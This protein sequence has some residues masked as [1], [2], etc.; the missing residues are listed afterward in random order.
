MM[1]KKLLAGYIVG[2]KLSHCIKMIQ[3]HLSNY[4]VLTMV[5][6]GV[7][8]VLVCDVLAAGFFGFPKFIAVIIASS[9]TM[10]GTIMVVVGFHHKIK[11]D[12]NAKVEQAKKLAVQEF[13]KNAEDE[14]NIKNMLENIELKESQLKAYD[15]LFAHLENIR[16]TAHN[17][18]RSSKETFMKY[19]PSC[20]RFYHEQ[21]PISVTDKNKMHNHEFVGFLKE[22]FEVELGIDY[23]SVAAKF[24][25]SGNE[26]IITG[27]E[28]TTIGAP[29]EKESI[30]AFGEIRK[31]YTKSLLKDAHA[32][33]DNNIEISQDLKLQFHEMKEKY[34]VE[35][36]KTLIDSKIREHI[37]SLAQEKIRRILAPL[38]CNIRFVDGHVHESKPF[39]S[40]LEEICSSLNKRRNLIHS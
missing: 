4:F 40:F 21:L 17:F 12:V 28:P 36:H 15:E 16:I 27:V 9:G 20:T 32:I 25:D 13:K 11:L 22:E 35:V 18:S 30:W 3:Y 10:L 37:I 33:I 31:H 26:I 29:I 2:E 39:I 8:L 6:A 1:F 7:L 23:E 24:N 14:K 34:K 19:S 38:G 5:I